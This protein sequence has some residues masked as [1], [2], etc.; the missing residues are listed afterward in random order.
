MRHITQEPISPEKFFSFT[1][2]KSC[3]ALAFFVGIV[4]NH[5]RGRPVRRLY[6]DCYSS[7]ADRVIGILVQ[8][9]KTRW[10]LDEIHVLHRIG[11]LEIGEAAVAIAVSSAHRDEAFRACRYLIEE[12]KKKVPIWKKEIFE[13]GTSEWVTC[14]HQV[15]G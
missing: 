3:G 1:P 13:D 5:D 7:M 14:S 8:A 6:Y 12:I 9:A 10:P 4:R 15:V 2:D 11:D